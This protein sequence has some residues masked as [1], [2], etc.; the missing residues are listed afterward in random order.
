M[1]GLRGHFVPRL[2]HAS[3]GR[4]GLAVDQRLKLLSDPNVQL[5]DTLL[6]LALPAILGFDR[7]I[8]VF[9]RVVENLDQ[10]G[11]RAKRMLCTS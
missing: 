8:K 7:E 9:L 4:E 6:E 1:T 2:Y 10:L 3:G 11:L 5:H